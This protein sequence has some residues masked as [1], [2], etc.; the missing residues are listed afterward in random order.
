M[1]CAGGSNLP[2]AVLLETDVPDLGNLL[3]I[4]LRGNPVEE[5]GNVLVFT[6]Y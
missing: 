4:Y 5:T 6:I 1:R 2:V 3:W